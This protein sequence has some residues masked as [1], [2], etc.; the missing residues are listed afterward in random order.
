MRRSSY[1]RLRCIDSLYIE[2]IYYE[3]Y[4]VHCDCYNY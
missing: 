3:T 4:S 2:L 1:E